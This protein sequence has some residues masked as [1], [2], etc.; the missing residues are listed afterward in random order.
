VFHAVE[1]NGSFYTQ[2]KAETFRRWHEQTP[3]DFCFTL[4]G[5]RFVT[6]YKRL[7]AVRG[8]IRLVRDPAR[9][10]GDKLRA[11][12][13][14]FPSRFEADVD[15]LDSFLEDLDALWPDVRHA[16][17]LRHDSWF[18]E[19]V[20]DKLSAAHVAVCMGDAPDF[21]MW[22]A[23]TTDLVY[24]RLHGHTRKYASSY[25]KPHLCR[26]AADVARWLE[27]G[28]EVHVYFDNDAEGAAIK[29]A[30]ALRTELDRLLG[31][32]VSGVALRP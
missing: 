19:S 21:P 3:D 13:W 25:S 32:A 1:V 31:R 18:T 14:Q 12:L 23:V 22:R 15:R 5:H 11:V 24:V 6:H 2:I 27:E 16:L 29:N 20:A 30:L 8:S 7:R 17:E 28:R 4:K 10:L 26:W 9:A